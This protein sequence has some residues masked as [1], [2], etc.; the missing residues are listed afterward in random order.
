MTYIT[1]EEDVLHC[2]DCLKWKEGICEEWNRRTPP[3]GFCF[4]AVEKI[5]A[6]E[7][8]KWRSQIDSEW[9]EFIKKK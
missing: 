8:E 7:Y 6:G 9:D 2:E 4:M 5:K 3:Y 1:D